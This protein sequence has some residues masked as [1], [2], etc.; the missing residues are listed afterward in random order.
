M[1]DL[2]CI[3][4]LPPLHLGKATPERPGCLRRETTQRNHK[5]SEENTF[6]VLTLDQRLEL[7]EDLESMDETAPTYEIKQ[8]NSNTDN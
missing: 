6:L 3:S 8:F 4:P 5:T 2:G 7:R 1:E